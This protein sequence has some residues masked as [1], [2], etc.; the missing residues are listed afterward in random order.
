M[1]AKGRGFLKVCGILMIIGGVLGCLGSIVVVL[2]VGA[3]VAS[4]LAVN[5]TLLIGASI[6]AIVASVVQLV[7]GI[8]GVK[9]CGNVEA[10]DKLIKLGGAILVIQVIS[11]VISLASG[12]AV[13]FVSVL[14]NCVVPGLFIYGAMKNKQ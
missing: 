2:G 1:E 12:Q 7:A 10:A 14:L 11:V 4:G 8:Q 13:N 3:L 9:N 6:L 5:T